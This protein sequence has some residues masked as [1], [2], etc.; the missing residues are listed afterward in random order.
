M[1]FLPVSPS[2]ACLFFASIQF[3]RYITAV[4][5]RKGERGR[6]QNMQFNQLSK[7]FFKFSIH[8]L[9]VQDRAKSS[10]SML[11]VMVYR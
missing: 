9:I 4:I 7:N 3:L 11:V 2:Y 8:Y 10:I 1:C 6:N 5:E